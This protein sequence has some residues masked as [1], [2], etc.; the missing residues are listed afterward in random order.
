MY[1]VCIFC[2]SCLIFMWQ[3]SW[4]LCQSIVLFSVPQLPSEVLA[5]LIS[6]WP[7]L[8]SM[9]A[10]LLSVQRWSQRSWFLYHLSCSLSVPM[11]RF[12]ILAVLFYLSVALVSMLAVLLSGPDH[13]S[14]VPKVLFF[15]PAVLVFK[16]TSYPV[17][18]PAV[19][20]YQQSPLY[21]ANFLFSMRNGLFSLLAYL[22]SVTVAPLS[23]TAVRF[24][25]KLSLHLLKLSSVLW[26]FHFYP[27][28]VHVYCMC[29]I[30]NM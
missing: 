5:V 27:Y 1:G 23:V 21:C 2:V 30:V 3:L 29:C 26:I 9:L 6:V 12:C 4:L 8:F 18:M 20:F 11:F 22:I 24:L 10:V 15:L 17:S 19:L 25:F 28:F 13:P 16:Y 14:S 7:V